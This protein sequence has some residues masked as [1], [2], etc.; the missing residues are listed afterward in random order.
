MERERVLVETFAINKQDEK[1][2]LEIRLPMDADRIT[3]IWVSAR[4]PQAAPAD[5]IT[6]PHSG[7]L[8]T[9]PN[10]VIGDLR[11]FTLGKERNFFSF[12]V[13][14]EDRHIVWGDV[15]QIGFEPKPWS[16]GLQPDFIRVDIGVSSRLLKGYYRDRMNEFAGFSSYQIKVYLWY[17]MKE[18]TEQPKEESH[19]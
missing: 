3:G 7:I 14:R 6:P 17:S 12:Q 1:K 13:S 16:H 8:T 11:L 15:S 2:A 10:T 4:F 9:Y 5:I 18:K 19:E